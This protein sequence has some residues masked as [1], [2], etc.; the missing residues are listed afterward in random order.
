MKSRIL[1]MLCLFLVSCLFLHAQNEQKEIN[2]IKSNKNYLYATGTSR[3]SADDASKNA[4]DLLAL[5]IEQWLRDNSAN[6][7]AGYVAKSQERLAMIST[8]RGN[9][10]RVFAFVKKKEVLPYYKEDDVMVVEMS[11]PKT[12]PATSAA[13]QETRTEDVTAI[14]AVEA[15]AVAPIEETPSVQAYVPTDAE[16]SMLNVRTFD[17]LNNYISKGRAA[18]TIKDSGKYATMPAT[19]TVYAF[20]YNREG[21]VPACIKVTDGK[22]LNLS[23]GKED[24]VTNYKGCGAVWVK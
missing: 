23:T 22:G 9:L 20:I 18:G 3:E 7:V 2:A 10:Y 24:A 1:L 13:Q 15:T 14:P 8:Q 4:K 17:A 12:E 16:K 19:G 11:E 5:E 21:Q 6:D